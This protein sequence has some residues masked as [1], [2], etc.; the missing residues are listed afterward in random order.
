M[1]LN[2]ILD[3]H[4]KFTTSESLSGNLG[5]GYLIKNNRYFRNIRQASRD[6]GYRFSDAPNRLYSS[7]PLSQLESVLERKTI[8]Y[9]NNTEVIKQIEGKIPGLTNWDDVQ[10]GLKK[11]SV[12]HESAHAVARSTT[13]YPLASKFEKNANVLRILIEESFANTCELLAIIDANDQLHRIFLEWN[14]YIFMLDDRANLKAAAEHFG[15]MPFFKY[16]QL[17]YLHSNFLS[18]GL[19]DKIFE[20]TVKLALPALR[21]APAQ[22][23]TLKTLSKIAFKLNPRFREI[24]TGFY[25]KLSGF[26]SPLAEIL[27]FD[28]LEMIELN[29]ELQNLLEEMA[30]TATL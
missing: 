15:K 27:N 26:T 3:H 17:A 1:R 22:L 7:L 29:E 6:A 25:F 16:M 30:I 24:T 8:P 5:D 12:F 23:K 18:D 10:D 28:F 13:A 9:C 14:S 21:L 19:N 11:N 2:R 20:R 4:L